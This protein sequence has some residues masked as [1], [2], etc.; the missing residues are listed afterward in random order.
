MFEVWAFQ[1]GASGFYEIVDFLK[2]I[3]YKFVMFSVRPFWLPWTRTTWL[4]SKSLC[5]ILRC[6]FLHLIP[7]AGGSWGGISV[8]IHRGGY[9]CLKCEPFKGGHQDSM[10][11]LIFWSEFDIHL[12]CSQWGRSGFLGLA[13]HGCCPIQSRMTR[14][15]GHLWVFISFHIIDFALGTWG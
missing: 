3:W 12:L 9:K 7:V 4:L 14:G 13:P 2:R 1:R 6:V 10:K 5:H 11:L 15:F 8:W